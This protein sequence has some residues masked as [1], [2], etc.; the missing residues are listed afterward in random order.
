MAQLPRVA[1]VA[2][3]LAVFV[4]AGCGRAT[5]PTVAEIDLALAATPPAGGPSLPI[6][7][8]A[9]ASNVGNTRV[10]HYGVGGRVLGPHG[11]EVVWLRGPHSPPPPPP[12]PEPPP[13][14]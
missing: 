2:G 5:R 12:P 10:W 9:R 4:A 7:V 8:D 14:P 3:A 6:V 1:L 13:P 11:V